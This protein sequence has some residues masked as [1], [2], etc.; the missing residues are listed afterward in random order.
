MRGYDGPPITQR[1]RI[2][3]ACYG[4]PVPL[5]PGVPTKTRLE[6]RFFNKEFNPH[7]INERFCF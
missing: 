6:A 5:V 2:K 1:I 4:M 3:M 7:L